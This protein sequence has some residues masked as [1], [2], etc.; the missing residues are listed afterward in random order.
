MSGSEGMERVLDVKARVEEAKALVRALQLELTEHSCKAGSMRAR[1]FFRQRD[2][3]K[4][5]MNAALA[6]LERHKKELRALSGTTGSDPRWALLAR[7]W[8][9][10]NALEDSGVKLGDEGQALLDAIEFHV[11]TAKLVGEPTSGAAE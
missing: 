11:P 6:E 2:N 1:D 10:L 3:I 5:R 4:R 8:R 7:T 9:Y